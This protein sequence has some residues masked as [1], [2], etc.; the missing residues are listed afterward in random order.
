MRTALPLLLG[1]GL[2]AFASLPAHASGADTLKA[3]CGS[4]HALS[5]PA[6][7]SIDSLWDRKAPDLYY[8]GVK[9]NRDWLVQWLQDPKPIR[10]AGYPY[11]KNVVTGKDH[12]EVDKSKLK[13]H[14]HL[15]KQDAEAVADALMAMKPDGIVEKG[16]FKGGSANL[17]MGALYFNKLRGCSACHQGE[18]GN[19]GFS[20]PELTDAGKRLQLDFIASYVKDPQKI[21]PH[22]WMP[23]LNMSDHDIQL[24]TAY[25]VHLG[26]EEKK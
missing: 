25:L 10:P 19:G 12:D 17:R 7:T 21:D 18:D 23:T 24:L 15:S 4:C 8:A 6:T 13:P 2:V 16:A 20:G 22:V 14:M 9:F 11:F 3:Q 5:K 26:T 1:L